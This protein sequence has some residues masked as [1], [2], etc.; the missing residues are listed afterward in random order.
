VV[1]TLDAALG[2]DGNLRSLARFGAEAQG[3]ERFNSLRAI[4]T[5]T[6]ADGRIPYRA[7]QRVRGFAVPTVPS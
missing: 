2:D 5:D 7:L 3:C 1:F 4:E 6:R